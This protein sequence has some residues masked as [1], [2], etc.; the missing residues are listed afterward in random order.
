MNDKYFN[1][2]RN[3]ELQTHNHPEVSGLQRG[4]AGDKSVKKIDIRQKE[5][6]E[7]L[8]KLVKQEK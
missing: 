1:R 3:D 5:D 4:G 8:Y 2:N 7:M 6:K